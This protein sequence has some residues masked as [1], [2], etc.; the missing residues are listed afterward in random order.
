MKTPDHNPDLASK[1]DR[2]KS[3]RQTLLDELH[4]NKIFVEWEDRS[5][6][7]VK[8]IIEGDQVVKRDNFDDIIAEKLPHGVFS[9]DTHPSNGVRD[10]AETHILFHV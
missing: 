3:I 6:K 2:V 4:T 10:W 1:H 8:M 9:Y 5:A 7:M